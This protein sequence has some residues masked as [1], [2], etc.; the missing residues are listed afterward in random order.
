VGSQTQEEFKYFIHHGD[1]Q[2]TEMHEEPH[3]GQ[4][5][6]RSIC[7]NIFLASDQS[8]MSCLP[9]SP[10]QGVTLAAARNG[11]TQGLAQE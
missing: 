8:Q 9:G 6:L 3:C 11:I 1:T 5:P 4:F 7:V 2:Y 10:T